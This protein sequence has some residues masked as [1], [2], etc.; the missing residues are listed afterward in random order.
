MFLIIKCN[1]YDK[2]L[3]KTVLTGTVFDCYDKR[4]EKL[5]Q[6]KVAEKIEIVKIEDP[7]AEVEKTETENAD[8]PAEPEGES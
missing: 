4:A 7:E 3:K 1:Y 2:E 8:V 5:L 6:A